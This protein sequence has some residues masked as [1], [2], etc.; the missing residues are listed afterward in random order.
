MPI[1]KYEPGQIVYIESTRYV[2]DAFG[3]VHVPDPE[4][5]KQAEKPKAPQTSKVPQTRSE[6]DESAMVSTEPN[7][8]EPT[9]EDANATDTEPST[10]DTKPQEPTADASTVCAPA[11][12]LPKKNS[13]P[14]NTNK[15][16]ADT[17]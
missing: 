5:S 6:P 9:D 1:H 14:A 3:E 17:K 11:A 15:K 13:A 16:E 7:Q 4:K 2:A 10:P 8:P 12:P